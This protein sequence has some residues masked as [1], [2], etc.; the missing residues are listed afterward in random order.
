METVAAVKTMIR[1]ARPIDRSACPVP[2]AGFA[3]PSRAH[4][5]IGTLHLRG[6]AAI[7]PM[8]AAAGD[9]QRKGMQQ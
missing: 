2:P 1:S 9:D 6:S 4:R 8:H 5:Q 7:S 3:V